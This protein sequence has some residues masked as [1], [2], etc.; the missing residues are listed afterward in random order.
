M[1][2]YPSVSPKV[3]V[4]ASVYNGERYLQESVESILNQTFSDFEFIIVD[5]GSTDGTADILKSFSD[6]RIVRL[7]HPT[8]QGFCA[9]LNDGLKAARGELIARHD[10]DIQSCLYPELRNPRRR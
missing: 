4:V 8:N 3:S 1:R 5:D 9:S 2:E 6:P 10:T 7:C